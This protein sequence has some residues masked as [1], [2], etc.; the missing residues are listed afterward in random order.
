MYGQVMTVLNPHIALHIYASDDYGSPTLNATMYTQAVSRCSF[1][2]N[3][4]TSHNL[5]HV[6]DSLKKDGTISSPASGTR[7]KASQSMTNVLQGLLLL[8]GHACSAQV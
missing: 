4:E 3:V 7:T 8:P 2:D 6:S 1:W 5:T